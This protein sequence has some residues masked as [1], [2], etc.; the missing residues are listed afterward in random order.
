M[1]GFWKLVKK[2][3]ETRVCD[4]SFFQT[5]HWS[6]TG[7]SSVPPGAADRSVCSRFLATAGHCYLVLG[8]W[9]HV[10]DWTLYSRD[11]SFPGSTLLVCRH[12]GVV[13]HFYSQHLGKKRKQKGQKLRPF[14]ITQ[15]LEASLGSMKHCKRV[16]FRWHFSDHSV[17]VPQLTHEDF[18]P[19]EKWLPSV[20]RL[21]EQ[22]RELKTRV[23][24]PLLRKPCPCSMPRHQNMDWAAPFPSTFALGLSELTF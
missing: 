14:L 12:Q 8:L 2:L 21:S 13:P 15:E 19:K 5:R 23:G 24:T 10:C 6:C 4:L 1:W 20:T 16:H 3:Q 17:Q 22:V 9:K 18:F 11:S 7:L